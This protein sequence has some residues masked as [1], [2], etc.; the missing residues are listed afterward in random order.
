[1]F[2]E[3]ESQDWTRIVPIQIAKDPISWCRNS[4]LRSFSTLIVLLA[5]SRST[6]GCPLPPKELQVKE[7]LAN[8]LSSMFVMTDNLSL[9]CTDVGYISPPSFQIQQSPSLDV[10]NFYSPESKAAY[11]VTIT[12]PRPRPLTAWF[13]SASLRDEKFSDQPPFIGELQY[14]CKT[15]HSG[16]R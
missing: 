14:S 2:F 7:W 1:M 13:S 5:K 6:N 9:S 12:A 3:V 4:K 11:S 8:R 15:C 16:P 10:V